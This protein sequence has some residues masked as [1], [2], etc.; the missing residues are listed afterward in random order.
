[1]KVYSKRIRIGRNVM[2]VRN[3]FNGSSEKCSLIQK[4]DFQWLLRSSNC[5]I[6]I[7]LDLWPHDDIFRIF[8]DIALHINTTQLAI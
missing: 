3:Y 4:F 7:L 8:V 2:Y 1:M 6:G 5:L